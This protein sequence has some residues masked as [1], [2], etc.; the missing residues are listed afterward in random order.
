MKSYVTFGF[1][2]RHEINGIVYDKDCVAVVNGNRE[3][4]FELFGNK[5]S[6]EYPHDKFDFTMMDRYFPRGLIEVDA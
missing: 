6:F 1:D 5:F 2:H 4:V 3:K